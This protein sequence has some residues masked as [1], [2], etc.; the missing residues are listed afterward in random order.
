V[1]LLIRAA[2][3]LRAEGAEFVVRIAGE[4]PDWA[5]LQRLAHELG[6]GD[7][8]TFLGPL[9]ESEVRT[10]YG[11][12]TAFALPCQVLPNGDRDG[13][14]NV[15]L[16]AMAHGLPV[17]ST[18]LAGVRE[19]VTDGETGLLVSPRDE[20][21]LAETLERLFSDGALRA[22]LGAR[23]R[24]RVAERFDRRANLPAVHTALARA[25]LI[26]ALA[27]HEQTAADA[28]LKE[29]TAA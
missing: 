3:R 24:Q 4:G 26:P 9:M 14:P 25:G 6:V 11:R 23:A 1:D 2:A 7:R 27:R 28:A 29:L 13:L 16:E 15:L 5:R 21:G 22:R 20:V 8:I 17:V 10:E 18:T 19:A 12:A